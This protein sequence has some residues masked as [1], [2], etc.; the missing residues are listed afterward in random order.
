MDQGHIS[1]CPEAC[2]LTVTAAITYSYSHL[3]TALLVCAE[4]MPAPFLGANSRPILCWE[5]YHYPDKVLF[6]C[7]IE[8]SILFLGI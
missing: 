7:L 5:E 8:S 4:A 3:F 6:M 1:G 2:L